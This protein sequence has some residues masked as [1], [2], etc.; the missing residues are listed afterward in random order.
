[1][2]RTL[3]DKLSELQNDLRYYNSLISV[4]DNIKQFEDDEHHA[5]VAKEREITQNKLDKTIAKI[6]ITEDK[7]KKLPKHYYLILLLLLMTFIVSLSTIFYL[8][9]FNTINALI[10]IAPLLLLIVV[11]MIAIPIFEFGEIFLKRRLLFICVVFVAF[12]LT[13]VPYIGS[14]FVSLISV[15]SC[16]ITLLSFCIG[17]NKT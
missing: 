14:A 7:V 17:G 5:I 4:F 8:F 15:I 1:M 2:E 13:Y 10:A 16:L 3:S 11:L 12:L 6:R 9:F